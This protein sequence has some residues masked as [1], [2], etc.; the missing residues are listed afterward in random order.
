MKVISLAKA[1]KEEREDAER[2][3][4]LLSDLN[5]E[6]IIYYVEAFEQKGKLCILT[7]YC[8]GGDMAEELENQNGVPLPECRI[9]EWLKQIC[10]GL[11]VRHKAELSTSA[12]SMIKGVTS[13]FVLTFFQFLHTRHV[14]HRDLK[15][16]NI[17]LTGPD[18]KVKLGDLGLAK[19]V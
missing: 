8:D 9:V 10:C 14:L 19:Y 12:M 11:Q 16:Q 13:G 17:Y 5:H 6:N 4:K 18:K 1:S 15:T 2:E 7:E 3:A